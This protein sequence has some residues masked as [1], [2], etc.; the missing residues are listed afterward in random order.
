MANKIEMYI[1]KKFVEDCLLSKYSGENG[2]LILVLVN[3]ST[4]RQAESKLKLFCV[5]E[6]F[7]TILLICN[8]VET[9]KFDFVQIL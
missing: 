5:K 4:V 3:N 9:S 8:T 2:T 7:V 1:K 6:V